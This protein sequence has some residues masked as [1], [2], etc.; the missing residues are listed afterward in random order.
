MNNNLPTQL[1][2]GG[3]MTTNHILNNLQSIA[4]DDIIDSGE[5]YEGNPVFSIRIGNSVATLVVGNQDI[6][7]YPEFSSRQI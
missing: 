3:N 6:E 1:S 5:D 4:E 2:I 7:D